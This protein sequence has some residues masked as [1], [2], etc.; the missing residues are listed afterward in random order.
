M[1]FVNE[2]KA[3]LEATCKPLSIVHDLSSEKLGKN[4]LTNIKTQDL[5]RQAMAVIRVDAIGKSMR[6]CGCYA[7]PSIFEEKGDSVSLAIYEKSSRFLGLAYCNSQWCP[8]C[9]NFSKPV[10]VNR[11]KQG[12]RAAFKMGYK[13]YFLTLT[14]PRTLD[15]EEQIETLMEG[16]K[17]LQDK[18]SYRLKKMGITLDFVRSLDVTFK[19]FQ[20][21]I[22]H[23]HLHIIF[24]IN[25]DF[26]PYFDWKRRTLEEVESL[27]LDSKELVQEKKS[28]VYPRY[29]DG[30]NYKV[31]IETINDLFALSW[32]DIMANKGVNV[33]LEAQ[34]IEEILEDNG[35]S[36][37]LNKFEGLGMEL[38]NFQHKSGKEKK[39]KLV[40]MYDSIG[41][42]ELVGY[43]AKGLDVARIVL[44]MFLLAVQNKRTM[45]FSQTWKDLELLAPIEEEELP[46]VFYDCDGEL[47]DD[48]SNELLYEVKVPPSWFSLFKNSTITIGKKFHFVIDVFPIAAY[49]AFHLGEI[50][51]VEHLLTLEPYDEGSGYQLERFLLT[52]WKEIALPRTYYRPYKG[53]L[54]EDEPLP[55]VPYDS[56]KPNNHTNKE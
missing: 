6:N 52:Y 19:L 14:T 20:E 23:A 1:S 5:L 10:R 55:R 21:D 39:G 41:Y 40:T 13:P 3:L 33:S 38:V 11:I 56:N 44:Q 26:V 35:L 2:N 32:H 43:V 36:G 22:Y 15:P 8:S 27:G 17:Y 24:V 18:V 34:H 4:F 50:A 37:Y 45:G 25:K 16:W 9:M 48:I 7:I 42:M 54:V 29:K 47:I 49:K 28:G 46:T 51:A 30:K 12:L 31:W 53:T